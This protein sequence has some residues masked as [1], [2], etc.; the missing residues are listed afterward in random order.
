MGPHHPH[1]GRNGSL[2]I[3][4]AGMGP[5]RTRRDQQR[6]DTRKRLFAAAIE[7]F[8]RDGVEDA[9]IED[10]VSIAGVSRGS[11]YFHFPT[12]EDVLAE[13]YGDASALLV[14]LVETTPPEIEAPALLRLVVAHL[15]ERWQGDPVLFGQVGLHALRQVARG[16]TLEPRDPVRV[17][18]AERFAMSL[19]RGDLQSPLA[20]ELL[21]DIFLLNAFTGLLAWSGNPGLPLGVMLDGVV[22]LFLTGAAGPVL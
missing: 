17:R 19:A 8:R 5:H 12:K 3:A 22:Q 7:V 14:E 4:S 10:I 15:A 18:L 6:D 20:P 13:A 16:M 9:R 11:F 1:W 21:A 2:R